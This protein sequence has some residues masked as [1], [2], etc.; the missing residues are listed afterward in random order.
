MLKLQIA[1]SMYSSLNMTFIIQMLILNLENLAEQ[2]LFVMTEDDCFLQR[3]ELLQ[4][5]KERRIL[6]QS[7][8]VYVVTN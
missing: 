2:R 5:S 1:W 7:A 3:T 4:S 6:N 8:L